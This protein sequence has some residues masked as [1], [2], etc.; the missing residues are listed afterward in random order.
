MQSLELHGFFL[1]S[2]D[3]PELCR[4]LSKCTSIEQ[5]FLSNNNLQDYGVSYLAKVLSRHSTFKL[6]QLTLYNNN[7]ISSQT[8][9]VPPEIKSAEDILAAARALYPRPYISTET[10]MGDLARLDAKGCV[11]LIAVQSTAQRQEYA[12]FWRDNHIK[13][14]A[15]DADIQKLWATM[16][17]I[18]QGPQC[19]NGAKPNVNIKKK[20]PRL[21]KRDVTRLLKAR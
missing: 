14:R 13:Q 16:P 10:C 5:L 3:L 20:K 12:V 4:S 18:S 7:Y 17:S 19:G 1:H 15:V 6:R 21:L 2:E 11:R 8:C 9:C